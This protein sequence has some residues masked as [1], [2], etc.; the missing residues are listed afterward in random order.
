MQRPPIGER[1]ISNGILENA[2]SRFLERKTGVL[3]VGT[4]KEY[5]TVFKSLK[6][7]QVH[8]HVILSFSDFN[9]SFFNEYERF[10]TKKRVVVPLMAL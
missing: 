5:R 10:K 1:I 6:D 7:F 4:L 2:A 9:Q 8:K 3:T